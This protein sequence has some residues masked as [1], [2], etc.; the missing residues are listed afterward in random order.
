MPSPFQGLAKIIRG[1]RV[2]YHGLSW[3]Q[4]VV[5]YSKI[6]CFLEVP[7]PYIVTVTSKLFCWYRLH[8]CHPKA[9]NMAYPELLLPFFDDLVTI[10]NDVHL[11]SIGTIL[12]LCTQNHN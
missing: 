11:E 3:Q 10:H 2:F 8:N 6:Q 4:D 12:A 9:S 7:Q 1:D 5:I